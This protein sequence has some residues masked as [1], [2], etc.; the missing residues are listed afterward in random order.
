MVRVPNECPSLNALDSREEALL[1]VRAE[2]R[3]VP[4]SR[5]GSRRSKM[6]GT[7]KARHSNPG[8]F[9]EIVTDTMRGITRN[10]TS[11]RN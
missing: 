10:K 3:Y 8:A 2:G 5:R 1:C 7:S 6:V 4:D 11:A 9:A